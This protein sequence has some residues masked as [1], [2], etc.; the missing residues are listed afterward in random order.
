LHSGYP[1]KSAAKPRTLWT[2]DDIAFAKA[3]ASG[4]TLLGSKSH[5]IKT[6][7]YKMPKPLTLLD[8]GYADFLRYAAKNASGMTLP[9]FSAAC[10]EILQD[11]QL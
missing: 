6:N 10:Q 5:I 1:E 3:K 4:V 7:Y 8:S 9:G 2:P 11:S